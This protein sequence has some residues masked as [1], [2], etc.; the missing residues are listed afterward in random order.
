MINGLHVVIYS[1][2]AEKDRALFKDIL[3]F[4]HVVV[5]HGWL[6]FAAPLSEMAFHLA[7]ENGKHEAYLMCD[8]VEEQVKVFE[9][10]GCPCAP[11]SNEGW[12]LLTSFTP[13]GGSSI[14]LYQSRHVLPPRGT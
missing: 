6:I 5:G 14:G 10:V 4:P 2:D 12:G 13:P 7:D 3:K 11:I 9:E 8:D 1:K